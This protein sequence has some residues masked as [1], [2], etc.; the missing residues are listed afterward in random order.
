[1]CEGT[2][3]HVKPI[4]DSPVFPFFLLRSGLA[5][6][7]D[8]SAVSKKVFLCFFFVRPSPTSALTGVVRVTGSKAEVQNSTSRRCSYNL[9]MMCCTPE[10]DTPQPHQV[11]LQKDSGHRRKEVKRGQQRW[12]PRCSGLVRLEHNSRT[13]CKYSPRVISHGRCNRRKPVS[14]HAS[15]KVEGRA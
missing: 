10:C 11:C 13:V 4:A 5:R 1:M 14:A 6:T 8:V 12:T 15:H 3:Q 9:D 2:Q 7:T